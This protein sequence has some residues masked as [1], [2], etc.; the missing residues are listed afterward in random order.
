MVD[1]AHH[2]GNLK[3]NAPLYRY[4]K[5]ATAKPLPSR[6]A[7][8]SPHGHH[9]R[10]LALPVPLLVMH[11]K[12][13]TNVPYRGGVGSGISGTDFESQRASVQPFLLANGATNMALA[14]TRGL[15]QRFESVGTAGTGAHVHYWWL[16]DGGHSWPGHGSAGMPNEPTNYDIDANDEIWAFFSQF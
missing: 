9:R 7:R 4:R 11:G 6:L 8:C 2:R 16:K 14:E 10:W 3:R 5:A 13:D 15:A 1:L 12:L